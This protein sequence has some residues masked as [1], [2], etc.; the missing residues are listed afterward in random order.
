MMPGNDARDEQRADRRVGGD[1]IHHH[2]DRRRDQDAERTRGRDDARAEA[3]RKALLD[4]RRQDD[5][6][7][8]DDGRRRTAGHRGE[9]RAGHDAGEPEP[10]GPVPD[11]R[12]GEVDHPPRD[13]AVGEEV[14]G[15][16]EERD[17]HD[18]E[19]LDAGEELQ[20]HR[21]DR[22]RGHRE[23][24]REHGEAE[25]D[26]DRHP[27]EHQAEE[28]RENDPRVVER[29]PAKLQGDGKRQHDDREQRRPARRVCGD[30][31]DERAHLRAPTLAAVAAWLFPKGGRFTPWD[32]RETLASLRPPHRCTVRDVPSSRPRRAL[33]DAPCGPWLRPPRARV[34]LI[35]ALPR[36]RRRGEG[37]PATRRG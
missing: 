28:Q 22:H 11:H 5:R 32:G 33:G 29:H 37:C 10:A 34:P 31:R 14:A 6:A 3:R 24:V 9:Q 16:D 25:R 13:A 15:E 17:R 26:R 27:G 18:L 8:R 35:Y 21:F 1:R 2:D 30:R 36:P 4:H 12:R 7:D 19:L 20:R 23:Q